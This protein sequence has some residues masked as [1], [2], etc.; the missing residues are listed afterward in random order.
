M[1]AKGIAD[2]SLSAERGA[3]VLETIALDSLRVLLRVLGFVVYSVLALLEPV[4]L[5]G[6]TALAVILCAVCG[7][8]GLLCLMHPTH[9]P[10]GF[11]FGLIVCCGL[12]AVGYY[13]VMSLLE[14]GA[15]GR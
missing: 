13:A 15:R 6:L 7:F 10:F 4:I 2:R 12:A 3:S 11:A 14:P 9:F 8:Y 1:N 5:Y